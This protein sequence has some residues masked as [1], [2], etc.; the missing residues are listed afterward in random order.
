L[1]LAPSNGRHDIEL[2]EA[3]IADLPA[4]VALLADDVIGSA[5]ESAHTPLDPAYERAFVAVDADP[6]ELLVVACIGSDVVGTL[7]CTFLHHLSHR[8]AVR[9]HIESVRVASAFRGHGIGHQLMEWTLDRARERGAR[10][11]QLS[12]DKSRVDAQRFYESLGFRATHEGMK[13]PL[14]PS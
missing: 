4:I 7:Q 13:L 14:D 2:R 11:A 12:T 3:T 1:T 8:G 5:R 6:D 9:A 10:V